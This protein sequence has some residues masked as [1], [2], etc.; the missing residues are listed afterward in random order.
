MILSRRKILLQ[1]LMLLLTTGIYAQHQQEEDSLL[2]IIQQNRG[3]T[4]E[5]IALV[6]LSFYTK[7]DD[8]ALIYAQEAFDL[9]RALK[10]QIGEGF[11]LFAF[12]NE[13]AKKNVS[14]GIQFAIEAL[15]LFERVKYSTGIVQTNGWLQNIYRDHVKDYRKSLDHAKYALDVAEK[16]NVIG[17]IFFIGQRYPP[18]TQAEIGQ[19]YIL[20]DMLDSALHFT[21]KSIDYDEQF[22]GSSWNFPY[23]LLAT[24]QV[25]KGDYNA[26]IQNYR[27]AKALAVP[28][29]FPYD[30]IQVNSGISTLYKNKGE[31]DSAK[32]Y[33]ISVINS[34]NADLEIKTLMEAMNN[35]GQVYKLQREKDSAIK[36]IEL[37]HALQASIFNEDKRRDVQNISFNEQLRRQELITAQSV[38]K[39]KVQKIALIGGLLTL[40]LVAS[41]LWRSNRH[42]QNSY[43]ILEKQKQETDK[44]KIKAE[45]ALEKLK[46]AQT[47]LI[48]SEKMASLGELTAGIAHEIQNPLNFVN[49]FSEV[50]TEL[51]TEMKKEISAGNYPEVNSIADDLDSNMQ[52]ITLHG[53]RAD[54]IVKSML[55]HS[56]ASSG[57]KEPTDINALAE[58]YLRLS[59][60]GIRARDKSFNAE[61]QTEFDGRIGNINIISQDIGRVLLNIYNNAFHAVGERKNEELKEYDPK[62]TVRTKRR[63]DFVEIL[64]S[65]NGAGIPEKI[66]D[67]IFQPFFTTK[68]TGEGTG[69]GLSLSYDMVKAHGGEIAVKSEEGEGT[70][71][72]ISLPD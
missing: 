39:N 52:K 12:G 35:L 49:N 27:L 48:Q 2:N 21:Q 55:Q 61:L 10:Y 43:T 30:T 26:A 28:N 60:H 54:A 47:Q 7:N 45:E 31:L 64:I 53:K 17:R 4:N 13:K 15:N 59:Y 41:I 40:L 5:V 51:I 29:D 16:N 25:R 70:T 22:Y 56:K 8:S 42:K 33:A 38:Y 44:Q 67:K 9:S 66:L 3:D 71:F 6:S 46:A 34:W 19:T 37:Y 20:M 36:Y 72:I 57:Q 1:M 18:L 23:Y 63:N 58:E 11:S 32:Y 24:I 50:N 65:D 14:E 69:L 68:P 62:V